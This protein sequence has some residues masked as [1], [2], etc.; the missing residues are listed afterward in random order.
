MIPKLDNLIK[1]LKS[2]EEKIPEIIRDGI[3]END[4][5]IIDMNVEDQLWEQGID[6]LG[7]FIADYA[8][9][10]NTTIE[11]KREKGQPTNRVTLRDEGDFHHSFFLEVLA[12]SFQIKA[13]DFK[14]EE[15]VR[16][17]GDE[18][19]GLTDENALILS[20]QYL[21]PILLTELKNRV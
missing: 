21:K 12:D 3:I 15:L 16:G 19:L 2:L 8:P 20:H 14:T 4:A 13:S 7:R 6:R 5:Y 1:S 11:I 9:Y 18:I 17:Y 10:A